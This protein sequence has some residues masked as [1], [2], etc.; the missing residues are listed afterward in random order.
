MRGRQPPCL[1]SSVTTEWFLSIWHV[2]GTQC[3]L[4]GEMV[5]LIGATNTGVGEIG[6]MAEGIKEV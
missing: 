4:S 3:T 6:E 1:C 5:D 2:V